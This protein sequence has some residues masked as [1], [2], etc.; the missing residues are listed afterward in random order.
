MPL[1]QTTPQLPAGTKSAF[2]TK[3]PN[4]INFGDP[5]ATSPE[6]DKFV[7][8][9]AE[10][11]APQ[12]PP[13]FQTPSGAT[14]G[15]GGN[16]ISGP[17]QTP[18][19]NEMNQF[20]SQFGTEATPENVAE[21]NKRF[22]TERFGG[23]TPT[24]IG[25]P[26]KSPAD[27][28]FASY[29]ASLQP[30]ES[31]TKASESLRGFDVQAQLDRERA[32]ETGE[33]LGFATGEA[34][35]VARQNAILR[36]GAAASVEAQV[37][38]DAN[39]QNISKAR[40]DFEQKKIDDLRAAESEGFTLSPGQTRFEGEK[41]IASL[42]A[43]PRVTDIP[44]GQDIPGEIPELSAFGE[45]VLN[46]PTLLES[47]TPSESGDVLREIAETGGKFSTTGQQAT[48]SL[49]DDAMASAKE[50][51]EH[52]GLKAAVAIPSARNILPGSPGREFRT[53][54]ETLI[55]RVTLPNLEFMR[56]LGHMSNRE[57]GTIKEASTVLAKAAEN[58]Y[59]DITEDRVATEIQ[60]ITDALQTTLNE[61][62]KIS[63]T[64]GKSVV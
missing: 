27:T 28:A 15:A 17:A 51:S 4:N 32:L 1:F 18:I 63:P 30:S 35:R 44:T 29:L 60:N 33:T 7:A 36:G 37:A 54:A 38:L 8:R 21:F 19:Q 57:F 40:Y 14:V 22:T 39:R 52:P 26:V 5:A 47:L 31:L 41:A 9:T 48:I 58:K 55:S 34:A 62:E 43:I 49:L 56:G 25:A 61:M 20:I 23:T 6:K 45:M 59:R 12:T 11:T 16:L 46:N 10:T 3:T 24:D 2:L 42:P 53:L 64:G 50:L 13:T